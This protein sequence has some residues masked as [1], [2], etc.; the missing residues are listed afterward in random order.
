MSFATHMEIKEL[1]TDSQ[2]FS[3]IFPSNESKGKVH[4]EPT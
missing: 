4:S 2:T 3:S 1:N